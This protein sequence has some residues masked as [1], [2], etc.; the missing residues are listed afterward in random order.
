MRSEIGLTSKEWFSMYTGIMVL[1]CMS[2][3]RRA[4]QLSPLTFTL[5][6][7]SIPYHQLKGSGF[8]K[9]VCA[10]HFTPWTSCPKA[11][12]VWLSFLEGLGLPSLVPTPLSS[13]KVHLPSFLPA[14]GNCGWS[15]LGCHS[16]NNTS[17]SVEHLSMLCP[18]MQWTLLSCFQYHPGPHHWCLPPLLF[19]SRCA[20]HTEG[21]MASWLPLSFHRWKKLVAL[22]LLVLA[23]AKLQEV[24]ITSSSSASWPPEGSPSMSFC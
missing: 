22:G 18:G 5:A 1:I 13:L 4:M 9:G 7:F 2:L 10:W 19:S 21:V 11:P 20:I 23:I 16:D 15:G 12:S 24:S 3:S 8:K 17:P 14:M 6:T